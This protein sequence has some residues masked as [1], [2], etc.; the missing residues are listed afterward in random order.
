M[1][2]GLFKGDHHQYCSNWVRGEG[3]VKCYDENGRIWDP[4]LRRD[5]NDWEVGELIYWKS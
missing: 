4:R 2:N 3:G 1:I 5:S